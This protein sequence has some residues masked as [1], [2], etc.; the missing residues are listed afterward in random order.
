MISRI[1]AAAIISAIASVLIIVTVIVV[2][3]QLTKKSSLS[4]AS[5]SSSNTSLFETT[6]KLIKL[7]ACIDDID[8]NSTNS[9]SFASNSLVYLNNSFI[10]TT[11][12]NG[13][14]TLKI[15]PIS[16]YT[17]HIIDRANGYGYQTTQLL[18]TD[19]CD[20]LF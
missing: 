2:A 9:C 15:D 12:I 7:S 19:D 16:N 14:I 3:V 13:S 18:T 20:K 5:S 4:N 1:T 17:L 8:L 11:D 6:T 10:G